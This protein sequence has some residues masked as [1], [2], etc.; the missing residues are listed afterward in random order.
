MG[1]DSVIPVVVSET[2]GLVTTIRLQRPAQRNAL[3]LEVVSSLRAA[4]EAAVGQGARAIVLTGA[5]TVFCAGADLSGPV[6]DQDFLANWV[7]TLGFIEQLPVPIIAAINGP[8]LGAGL[9]LAMVAD[10]RVMSPEAIVGIPAAKIGVAVDD[11]TIKR[12]VSLV[13]AGMARGMFIG[14]EPLTAVKAEQLGFAN[15]IGDLAAAQ[16][17]A[18]TVATH[19]PLTVQSYKLVLN[20]D[21]A[22]DESPMH[23]RAA[24]MKAWESEDLQEGKLARLEKRSPNFKGK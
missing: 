14:C 12:L 2:N 20:D 17:F 4:F 11:W 3:N 9:Q 16:E 8:A 6:Y 1:T 22:R 13:G 18:K 5:G 7:E 21:G 23:H 24:M 10:L 19:A 15:R